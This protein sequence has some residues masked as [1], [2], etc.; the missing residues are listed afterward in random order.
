MN[1]K[2]KNK[3]DPL[4]SIKSLPLFTDTR[5]FIWILAGLVYLCATVII[6]FTTQFYALFPQY[7][8]HDFVLLQNAP[9]DL[10]AD[11]DFYWENTEKTK[12]ERDQANRD[13]LL[14]FSIDD[15]KTKSALERF[16]LFKEYVL[17]LS[18]GD[19]EPQKRLYFENV[20]LNKLITAK[21][22]SWLRN[23]SE[24]KKKA[25]F[26][27]CETLFVD[28]MNTGVI[29]LAEIDRNLL[30]LKSIQILREVE[31]RDVTTKRSLGEV[32]TLKSLP[33][34]LSVKLE[35]QNISEIEKK[36]IAEI[37]IA[38]ADE[39]GFFDLNN[40][41]L[42]RKKAIDEV[43]PVYDFLNKG[44]PIARKGET[45]TR[46]IFEKIQAYGKYETVDVVRNILSI[47]IFLAFIILMVMI[48]FGKVFSH[49][50]LSKNEMVFLAAMGLIFILVAAIFHT[51]FKLPEWNV[52]SLILPTAA[53]A[54]LVTIFISPNSGIIM[55]LALASVLL[56]FK[57]DLIV[58]FFAFFS[59]IAGSVSVL[60]TARR[61]DLVR[62]G[63]MLFVAQGILMAILSLLFAIPFSEAVLVCILAALN[64]F[65]SITLSLGFLP[66]L[67]HI[68]NTPTRFRLRELS[69]TNVP[70]L[71]KLLVL[72]P[73]TYSHS[74][75]VANLAESASVEIGANPLL[76]RVGAYYHDIGKID[77]PEYFIENQRSGNVHDTLKPSL[78]AAVI[79]SHV[80]LGVEK[81]KELDLPQA[82]IDII[83]Q[84]HGK[85]I[86]SYFYNR[87]K[88]AAANKHEVSPEDFSYQ[89]ARPRSREAA[90]VMLADAVE[91]ACRTLKKPTPAKIEKM[92]WSIIIDRF[93]EGELSESALTMRDLETI[94]TV[95]VQII[96]GYSHPRIAY[97][98]TNEAVS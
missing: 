91:A 6:I 21:S 18:S 37:V 49:H 58:F 32:V 43:E 79:K 88:S 74:M 68:L 72:A 17:F 23:N 81:A 3:E 39:N 45:I 87:A 7:N 93:H 57:M 8:I 61:I 20:G 80:K 90:V 46:E 77:Q 15:E 71:K 75:N 26:S 89:G 10:V 66:L 41:L 84:H 48:L 95:F 56:L 65:F 14:V 29:S 53:I 36:V 96:Q 28:I 83:S 30:S 92:I 12:K 35:A 97:P 59:G 63:F 47:C 86:I 76:A 50:P 44:S 22:F 55:S 2:N 31:G 33:S 25:L 34:W 73:G 98:R 38:C 64:G 70:I 24:I 82:V 85:G 16:A 42:N 1:Q 60:H 11:R 67:E 4:L 78:S 5:K 51:I 27:R 52:F 19:Q 40:T 94:K 13:A 62:A 69:D 9:Y 54:V